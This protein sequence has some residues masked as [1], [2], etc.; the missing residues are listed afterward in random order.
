MAV[1]SIAFLGSLA[2]LVWPVVRGVSWR[3]VCHDIGW[4]V[5]RRPWLDPLLGVGGYAMTLPLLAA[6]VMMM[7]FLVYAQSLFADPPPTFAPA[8]GPAHPVILALT[9]D[10][11]WP[12]IQVLFLASVA[13]PIVEETMFRGV[14]YR[15]LR[16]ATAGSGMATSVIVSTTINGFLFAIIHPQ[17]WVTVPALMALAY[18]FALMREWRDSVLPSMLMH[19]ISNGLV[20]SLLIVVFGV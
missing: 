13:A 7:L 10:S 5:G 17:G 8:G 6:G 2:A 15:H 14:L 19:G 3:D 16:G 9:G 11:W 4:T 12:K 18:G 20:I 1:S